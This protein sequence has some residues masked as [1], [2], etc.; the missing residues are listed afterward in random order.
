MSF[1]DVPSPRRIVT[2]QRADGTSYFA[3]VETAAPRGNLQHTAVVSR[4]IWG[5]DTG[6]TLLP[7]DGKRVPL[8][9]RPTAEETPHA[10]GMNPS[11][12]PGPFGY[13]V[14]TIKFPAATNGENWSAGLHWHDTCDVLFVMDGEMTMGLDG[15]EEITV[16]QGDVIIQH[17]TNHWYRSGPDGC[18]L[19]LVMM[20]AK[21]IGG[22]EG[23]A[24]DYQDHSFGIPDE[25]TPFLLDRIE[26][27]EPNVKK[28]RTTET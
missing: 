28:P 20:G 3:R 12:H 1:A 5:G 22:A 23:P 2:G 17:G 26:R 11:P 16:R 15:G 21:R 9:S 14:S 19:G 6:P 25:I 7:S 10:L 18:L 4:A 27:G 13:R 8:R 24:E